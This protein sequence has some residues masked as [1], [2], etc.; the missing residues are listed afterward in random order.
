MFKYPWL[1]VVA[2]IACA[3]LIWVTFAHFF[4]DLRA[5][6][7]KDGLSLAAGV[8]TDFWLAT[9]SLLKLLVFLVVCAAY[10]VAAY[11]LVVWLFG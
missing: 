6:L 11:K 8:L 1:V 3:P 4:P 2:V 7:K 10:L 9:W 5:D